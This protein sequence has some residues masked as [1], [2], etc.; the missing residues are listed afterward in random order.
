MIQSIEKYIC[1]VFDFELRPTFF[2]R[3]GSFKLLIINVFIKKF[4]LLLPYN[5]NENIECRKFATQKYFY[6]IVACVASKIARAAAKSAAC[7]YTRKTGSVP[8]GR[9]MTHASLP[10]LNLKPSTLSADSMV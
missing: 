9:N 7:A 4:S 6:K 3:D 5:N 8:E 10:K 2:Y 1:F